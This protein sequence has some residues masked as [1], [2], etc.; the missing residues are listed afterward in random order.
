MKIITIEM[1]KTL[2]IE[3]VVE[4][5]RQ[6]YILPDTNIDSEKELKTENTIINPLNLLSQEHIV[7]RLKDTI[8]EMC[9]KKLNKSLSELN[10]NLSEPETIK[11]VKD[12]IFEC[13]NNPAGIMDNS[14]I[15]D[16]DIAYHILGISS[17]STNNQIKKRFK[18]LSLEY[19]PSKTMHMTDTIRNLVY[20]KYRQISC[21]FELLKKKRNF[22]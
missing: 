18:E 3:D 9:T 13:L 11:T 16:E 1:L 12:T 4:L 6:G 14:Y 21:A 7:R 22:Q 19:H 15:P 20:E 8:I 2:T 5:Y 10:K 17:D